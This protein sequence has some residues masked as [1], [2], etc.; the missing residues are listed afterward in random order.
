[1]TNI[2]MKSNITLGG[3]GIVENECVSKEVMFY[4]WLVHQTTTLDS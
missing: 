3:D 1:M 4:T 2:P